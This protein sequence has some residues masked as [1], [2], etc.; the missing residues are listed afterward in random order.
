MA[1][2]F[3]N[4]P[5]LND[6][7]MVGTDMWSWNGISWEVMP[8]SLESKASMFTDPVFT[9]TASGTFSG[10][11]TGNVTGNLTG[12]VTGNADTATILRTTRTINNVNFNGSASITLSTL[13]N[14]AKTITLDSSGNLT[15]PGNI[16]TTTG[17]ISAN[18]VTVTT[19]IS[20]GS[21][22]TTTDITVGRNAIISTKPT[23][24]T[25]ATNKKYVDKR[26][27]AMA[28]ALS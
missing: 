25:H 9:G 27:T 14:G 26:A 3:P 22:A 6:M 13:V 5:A 12:A 23:L 8:P 20:A 28:I 21:A 24:T 2:N 19:L 4:N 17:I 7:F 18:A 1:M 10:N 11:L 15:V 16:T